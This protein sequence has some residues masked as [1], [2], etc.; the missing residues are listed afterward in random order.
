M[1][2]EL[3]PYN[4]TTG[5]IMPD[6]AAEMHSPFPVKYAALAK[7]LSQRIRSGDYDAQGIPGERA[8]AAE[9]GV[10]RVT[11]RS[12]LQRLDD[13]GLVWR[14]ERRGTFAI[15]DHNA[16]ARRRL[17]REDMDNFL[18]R[19]RD[20]R[21]K[22]LLFTRTPA[23]AEVASALRLPTGELVLRVVRL[24]TRDG[25]ALTYTDTYL[26]LALA[27]YVHRRDLERKPYVQL[28]EEAGLSISG[29]DQTITSVAAPPVVA[30]ALQLAEGRPLLKLARTLFDESETPVQLLLGW[31]HADHFAIGMRMSRLLD[32]TRVWIQY[33]P[34]ALP[35]AGA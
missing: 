35:L 33:T 10:A 7:L 20:D 12:A 28:L 27:P 34:P 9:F 8:L 30:R 13:Q 11:I 26:R 15:S 22:V 14:H 17:L 23:T 29:A 5:P 2:R 4:G 25:V 6:S 18:D 24:R 31:Y 32:A 3:A 1:R 19:G 16:A 21:R